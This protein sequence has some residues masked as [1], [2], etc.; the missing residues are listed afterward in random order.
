MPKRDHLHRRRQGYPALPRL[1]HRSTRGEVHVPGGGL[2]AS[3]RGSA[4]GIPTER[5]GDQYHLP[6]HDSRD[7]QEVSGGISLERP[8]HGDAGQHGGGAF[9]GLPRG[10]QCPRSAEPQVADH[11]PDRQ[12]AD[13]CGVHLPARLG[14][15]L[16]LSGQ[17]P[18]LR[19]ELHEHALEDGGAQVPGQS[20]P[21]A[22]AR[23]PVHPARRSRA[24][25]QRQCH[26][27]G[28]QLLRRSVPL[29]GCGGCRALRPPAR[30][31]QRRSSQN[32]GC[33]RLQGQDPSLY[34]EG[35]G[36]ASSS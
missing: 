21:G 8:S 10:P 9:H 4:H 15:P 2:P 30:R 26:A 24:E 35:Q 22:R 6:H 25:L 5:V 3:V 7:H 29:D 36:R 34:R 12:N 18:R 16:H 17:R 13:H 19:R 20:R 23:Y 1:P 31:G 28:G 11:A 33:D 27:R 32:A 14:L